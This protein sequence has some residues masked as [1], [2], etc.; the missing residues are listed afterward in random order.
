MLSLPLQRDWVPRAGQLYYGSCRFGLPFPLSSVL[1]VSRWIIFVPL[2]SSAWE[3]CAWQACLSKLN[4]KCSSHTT[5]L[6]R[7]SSEQE[8]QRLALTKTTNFQPLD[9]Q[10]QSFFGAVHEPVCSWK[11]R[12][13]SSA[14]SRFLT[15]CN[16][17]TPLSSSPLEIFN[18]LVGLISFVVSDG[19]QNLTWALFTW[20]KELWS[21]LSLSEVWGMRNR[22]HTKAGVRTLA[23]VVNH[24]VLLKSH[25]AWPQSEFVWFK[26]SSAVTAPW[27]PLSYPC[28]ELGWQSVR[29]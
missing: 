5:N 14:V 29:D 11:V 8:G 26:R 1:T 15:F 7:H 10:F 23:C 9:Y 13:P 28:P 22:H 6:T 12:Y 19:F 16:T 24:L 27:G 25:V 21:W 2:T 4:L 18:P 3:I 17:H 20:I